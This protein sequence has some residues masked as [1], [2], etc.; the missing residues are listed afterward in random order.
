MRGGG[1]SPNSVLI[2]PSKTAK[3]EIWNKG[4]SVSSLVCNASYIQRIGYSTSSGNNANWGNVGTTEM[5][6]FTDY[7][8]LRLQFSITS[9]SQDDMCVGYGPSKYTS[10]DIYQ[11]MYHINRR[12]NGS[13]VIDVDISSITGFRYVIIVAGR[14][15]YYVDRVELLK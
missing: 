11:A 1:T 2:L 7:K 9:Y 10:F 12:A 15:N 8:T 6:D 3:F 14:M 4:G 13:Y 5:Y